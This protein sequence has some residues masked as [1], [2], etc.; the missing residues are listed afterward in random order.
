MCIW[1]F[2]V[3]GCNQRLPNDFESLME[4]MNSNDETTSVNASNELS[5]Q[6]GKDGLLR[7]LAE[8]KGRARARAARWLWRYEGR[9]VEQALL[10]IVA[11]ESDSYLR[12]QALWSL[13][14][15][16]SD[17]ALAT[18][19]EA[20]KGQDPDVAQMATKASAAIRNRNEKQR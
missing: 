19:D 13:A 18:V 3:S 12:V 7:V 5:T 20:A 8:G 6:F 9:D 14:D 10:E 1:I 2:L 15:I 17:R 11:M 4:L 16:G